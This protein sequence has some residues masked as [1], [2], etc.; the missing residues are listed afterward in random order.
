MKDDI[1]LRRIWW[2]EKLV[3]N[4]LTVGDLTSLWICWDNSC[5]LET[6]C[7]HYFTPVT[8]HNVGLVEGKV[9][10]SSSSTLFSFE[11]DKM[12][13]CFKLYWSTRSR[14]F[15][16][17]IKCGPLKQHLSRSS[18]SCRVFS[19]WW[20]TFWVRPH[21]LHSIGIYD[22]DLYW[23]GMGLL[24]QEALI[25]GSATFVLVSS[26]EVV[27]PWSREASPITSRS[28]TDVILDT[29]GGGKIVFCFMGNDLWSAFIN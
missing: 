8:D 18:E 11:A 6:F 16:S 22:E 13:G 2:I 10:E 5:A 24:I 20:K 26:Y 1:R 7:S 12:C 14:I 19:D 27:D 4:D 25:D 15:L 3:C 28:R 23:L 21:T 17:P 29:W 9:R